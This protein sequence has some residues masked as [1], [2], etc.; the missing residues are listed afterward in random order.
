M[1][2]KLHRLMSAAPAAAVLGLGAMICAG[3][4]TALAAPAPTG[5][6]RYGDL[7]INTPQGVQELSERIHQAAWDYCLKV[8]PP[9]AAPGEIDNLQCREALIAEALAKINNPVL[10]RKFPD[11]DVEDSW[12]NG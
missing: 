6:I 10:T 3:S 2:R 9:A 1:N 11:A 8:D 7:D 5:V 4:G 12:R